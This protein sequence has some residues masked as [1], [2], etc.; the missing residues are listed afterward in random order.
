MALGGNM[1]LE[2]PT[3]KN[4]RISVVVAKY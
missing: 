2:R 4:F 1:R 3:E